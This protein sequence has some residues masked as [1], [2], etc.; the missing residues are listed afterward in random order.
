MIF[1]RFLIKTI[2]VVSRNVRKLHT[3]Q[4]LKAIQK[5]NNFILIKKLKYRVQEIED[6]CLTNK[7]HIFDKL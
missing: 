2:V 7:F 6:K 4:A 3:N 1:V 5:Q